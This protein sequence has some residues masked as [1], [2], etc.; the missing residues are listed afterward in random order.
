MR[1]K[2]IVESGSREAAEAAAEYGVHVITRNEEHWNARSRQL[3][4]MA[5]LTAIFVFFSFMAGLPLG[6]YIAYRQLNGG[7]EGWSLL[8]GYQTDILMF[9]IVVPVLI[10]FLGYLG[11]RIGAMVNA[12]ESIAAAAQQFV[13]PDVSA[14]RNV[15]TVG[16]VVRGHMATLNE[17]LDGALTRLASVESMIRQHVEAIEIAGEAIEQRAVG[18]VERVADERS[19][20]MDLTESLNAHADSFAAAIAERA[21]ASI[22]ALEAADTVSGQVERD[23]DDRLTRLEDAAER[24]LSSFEALRDALRDTDEHMR[25]SAQSIDEAAD[26]TLKA[27]ERANAASNAAA[28]S[29]PRDR[30]TRDQLIARSCRPDC[31]PDSV[32]AATRS[33]RA[34]A[35]RDRIVP[36]GQPQ[37]SAASA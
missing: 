34:R 26:F 21:K 9:A 19:R 25:A 16:E 36:T 11:S 33:S 14:M 7:S 6:N 3:W 15:D 32:I 4:L 17:G 12:A 22:E 13:T 18:A 5:R 10:V 1:F 8:A 30:G 29:V 20:L 23:F 37:T 2:G 31:R 24:A 28:D 35:T 27:T